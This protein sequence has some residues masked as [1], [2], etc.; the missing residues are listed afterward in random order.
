[1]NQFIA[2]INI[3]LQKRKER[4]RELASL[5]SWRRTYR[6]NAKYMLNIVQTTWQNLSIN[7]PRWWWFM[8]RRV[9]VGIIQF[10][11]IYT[12]GEHV[13]LFTRFGASYKAEPTSTVF[14]R[15]LGYT[16]IKRLPKHPQW[17]TSDYFIHPL[18]LSKLSEACFASVTARQD[19]EGVWIV[20]ER[21]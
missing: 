20:I 15:L 7:E 4:R 17:L 2:S 3:W 11:D 6:D 9:K 21:S 8:A 14:G 1:M 19:A 16:T 10:D 18:T 12:T 13:Y 5:R